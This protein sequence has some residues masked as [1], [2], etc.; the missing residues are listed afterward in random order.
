MFCHVFH[1]KFSSYL[2][3]NLLIGLIESYFNK[4]VTI[5]NILVWILNTCLLLK[6]SSKNK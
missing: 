2:L 1:S 4:I 5:K 6:I 3:S